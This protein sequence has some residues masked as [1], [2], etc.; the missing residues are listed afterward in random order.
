[1]KTRRTTL[2]LAAAL[3]LTSCAAPP[4]D[5]PG[6]VPTP[7]RAKNVIVLQGDGMGIATAS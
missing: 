6:E 4:G 7:D 2:A 3:T 1:M 5:S